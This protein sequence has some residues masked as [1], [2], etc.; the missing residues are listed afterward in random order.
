MRR[1]VLDTSV[2]ASAF[3]SREGASYALLDHIADR[4]LAPLVTT[5]LF[6]QYEEVLNRPEQLKA[7]RLTHV[8]VGQRLAALAAAA[9]AVS[10]YYSLRPQ[11]PDPGDELVFEAATRLFNAVG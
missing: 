1:V 9:E 5:A 3:R 11:L 6:L 10:V 4:R 2:V 7:S 8:E